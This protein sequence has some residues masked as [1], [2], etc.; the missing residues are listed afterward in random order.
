MRLIGDPE[1]RY[2]EDPVRML[3]AARFAGKLDFEVDAAT[4]KPIRKMAGLIDDVP[5]ARLFDEFLKLFQSGYALASF[6]NL[7]KLGLFEHLFP[8]TA[9]WITDGNDAMD[10]DFIERALTNTDQRVASGMSITPM[11]LFGVF[12]WRSVETRTREL[13][14]DDPDFS[15]ARAL[16][17]AVAEVSSR[18][19]QRIALPR[20]FSLPMREMLQ[21]QPRFLKQQGRRPLKLLGHRRFRAAYDL[22]ILRAAAGDAPPGVAD[23]WTK[24]QTLPAEEQKK[25]FGIGGRG[26]SS[27]RPRRSGA[28]P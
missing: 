27:R 20:R 16:A 13:L 21:L 8:D 19:A 25:A 14:D 23:F 11:F 6:R 17:V 22:L 7:R 10:I 2:R 15:E 24:V 18:Q 1:T 5:A 9:R 26:R 4:A 3:R 28:A 12:L